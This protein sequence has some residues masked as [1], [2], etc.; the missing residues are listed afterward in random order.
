MAN[1]IEIRVG[2]FV[3]LT[4][5]LLIAAV[6][7]LA[8]KKDFFTRVHTFTLS[9]RVG[10]DITEGMPVVF[11]GFKIGR[12]QTM[13]LNDAGAVIVKIRVPQRHVQWLRQNSSFTVDKP[14]L[15]PARLLVASPEPHGPPLTPKIVP[16]VMTVDNIAEI[17]RKVQPIMERVSQMAD[18]LENT[19]AQI[20]SPQGDINKILKNTELLT[21]KLSQK[22]S[23]LEMAVNDQAAVQAIHESLRKTKD[24]VAQLDTILKRVDQMAQKT[25]EGLY[26]RE[27]LL[28]GATKLLAETQLKLDKLSV[29]LDNVNKITGDIAD[30]TTNIKRLRKELDSTVGNVNELVTEINRKIPFRKQPE[31][32]LP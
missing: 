7:F 8:Y 14:L 15:G 25:D 6:G 2:V 11:S 10:D 31:I 30:S 20:A 1:K 5:L 29:S 26:G 3:I 12:V 28:P 4:S 27:G 18:H 21:A 22:N 23:L 13:E 16:E 19:M 9:A 32:K 17:A 24:L